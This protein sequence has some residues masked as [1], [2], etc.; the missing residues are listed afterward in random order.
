MLCI[1]VCVLLFLCVGVGVCVCVCLLD[2]CCCGVG[3]SGLCFRNSF[4][5]FCA[6]ASVAAA[7]QAQQHRQ[8]VAAAGCSC[9][10][11]CFCIWLKDYGTGEQLE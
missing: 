9:L 4:V 7:A 11:E 3:E 8:R 1:D 2:E 10:W 5:M 6:A